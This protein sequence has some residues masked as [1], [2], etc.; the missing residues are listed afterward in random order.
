MAGATEEMSIESRVTD[1]VCRM[2]GWDIPPDSLYDIGWD[3]LDRIEI[4][5]EIED[6][7]EIVIPDEVTDGFR[8]ISDI[9]KAVEARTGTAQTA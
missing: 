6:E 3:S 1:I 8:T 9:V 5:I 4:S 7:F 2:M